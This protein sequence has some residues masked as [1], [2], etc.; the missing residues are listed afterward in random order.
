MWV[1]V[2]VSP[3]EGIR[4]LELELHMVVRC[5]TLFQGTELRFSTKAISSLKC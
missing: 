1:Q 4:P 3:A 2:P 5:P